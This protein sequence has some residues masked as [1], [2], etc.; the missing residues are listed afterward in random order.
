MPKKD[1]RKKRV[2]RQGKAMSRLS[3]GTVPTRMQIGQAA[4]NHRA[5]VEARKRE[6]RAMKRKK[7]K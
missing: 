7:K 2:M 1:T 6:L 5:A 4:I 3:A